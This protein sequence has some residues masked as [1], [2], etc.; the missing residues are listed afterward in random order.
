MS[1]TLPKL[2]YP[3]LPTH[4]AWADLNHYMRWPTPLYEPLI[5]NADLTRK[6]F[7]EFFTSRHPEHINYRLIE[8][9]TAYTIFVRHID[10]YFVHDIKD[11]YCEVDRHLADPLYNFALWVKARQQNILFTNAQDFTSFSPHRKLP[12]GRETVSL[13]Q[14]W[15]AL[16]AFGSCYSEAGAFT[17][18]D[19]WFSRNLF[20]RKALSAV[21]NW[22]TNYNAFMG[23]MVALIKEVEMEFSL[24]KPPRLAWVQEPTVVVETQEL[25]HFIWEVLEARP[26]VVDT[27]CSSLKFSKTSSEAFLR[28]YIRPEMLAAIVD[29]IPAPGWLLHNIKTGI[30]LGPPQ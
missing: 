9:G 13:L 7:A 14:F 6:W 24:P 12:T 18:E 1:T 25:F 28:H 4:I 23:Q 3:Q 11:M 17:W 10:E 19:S 30:E 15:N 27:L 20:Q 26:A 22:V 5:V 8:I 21:S 29:R 2:F 16:M